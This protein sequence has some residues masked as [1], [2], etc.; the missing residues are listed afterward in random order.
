MSVN[1]YVCP[2]CDENIAC[3]FLA[4]ESISEQIQCYSQLL[5][6]LNKY[7][8][9]Y[10]QKHMSYYGANSATL[11]KLWTMDVFSL[12]KLCIDRGL[13]FI[14]TNRQELI[15][16]LTSSEIFARTPKT[17][18]QFMG[19]LLI[20]EF[21]P[22][23]AKLGR[24][25]NAIDLMAGN[26]N[27]TQYIMG[28][29]TI[30]AIE[31]N[32]YRCESGKRIVRNAVWMNMD[33]FS[34]LFIKMFI[35]NDKINDR[36]YKSMESDS[37]AGMLNDNI[38]IFDVVFCTPE[39]YLIMSSI[40]IGLQLI[41]KSAHPFRCLC[42]LLPINAF[43]GSDKKVRTFRMLMKNMKCFVYKCYEIGRWNYYQDRNACCA[44]SSV[45]TNSRK[46]PTPDAIFIFRMCVDVPMA[47][48]EFSYKT[49]LATTSGMICTK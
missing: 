4:F 27:L 17:L 48:D 31:I 9:L 33:I 41:A 29:D 25:Y 32:K 36:D 7:A 47:C 20:S 46:K 30:Y 42:Y 39:P 26:G 19:S 22:H 43:V 40:Y 18:A 49:I 28:A 35:T 34:L 10:H 8:L 2:F 13:P 14:S 45:S 11:K 21:I 6:N 24:K 15:A 12:K 23:F 44:P 3:S 5:L 37:I 1:Q 38:P 16:I